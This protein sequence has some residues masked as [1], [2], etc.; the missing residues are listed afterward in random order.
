[1][2]RFQIWIVIAVYVWEAIVKKTLKLDQSLY[3]I[4]QILSITLFE[5][6]PIL[7]ALA[8]TDYTDQNCSASNKLQLCD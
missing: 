2:L 8:R 4:L 7:R 5:K 1:M 6:T 3:T